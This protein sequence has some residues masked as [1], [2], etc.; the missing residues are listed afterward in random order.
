MDLRP[1]GRHSQL[2]VSRVIDLSATPILLSGSGY[3]EGTLFPWTM[4]DFSLMDAIECGIVKL[5]RVPVADNVP[6]GDTPIFRNLW[7]HIGKKMPKKG[8]GATGRA[9]D[10]LNL[11]HGKPVP[12]VAVVLILMPGPRQGGRIGPVAE[13]GHE[14]VGVPDDLLLAFLAPAPPGEHGTIPL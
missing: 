6:G 13:Q 4:C 2:G 11:P 9:L 7:E 10:P 14:V 8:R 1:G 5:P 12:R 3:A